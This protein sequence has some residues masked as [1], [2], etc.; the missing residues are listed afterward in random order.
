MQRVLALFVAALLAPAWPAI[1]KP[2]VERWAIKTSIRPAAKHHVA[3]KLADFLKV[4]QPHVP[5]KSATFDPNTELIPH[6]PATKGF[7]EGDI[8]T[9]RGWLHL[10]AA[11]SGAKG[12]EDYHIQISNSRTDGDNCVVVESPNPDFITDPDLKRKTETI[13]LWVRE[14]LLHNKDKE[15]SQGGNVMKGEVYVQATGQLF[16]DSN[17][18]SPADPSGGRG[19]RGMKA[20]TIWELHPLTD[21]RFAPK[22]H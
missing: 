14:R 20:G 13:R 7:N 17:H 12:D 15:P 6:D 18:A 22:P 4:R 3:T 10:V 21:L 19:K 9:I 16:F 2:G 1:G 11:E 8:V 5:K